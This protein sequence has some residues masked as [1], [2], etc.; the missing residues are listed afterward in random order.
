MSALAWHG[1]R[2]PVEKKKEGDTGLL[3]N[4]PRW[5]ATHFPTLVIEA[6]PSKRITARRQSAPSW[7]N[8]P[9]TTS[10]PTTPSPSSMA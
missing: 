4:P 2:I 6:G 3:P 10:P 8:G 1:I 5:A 7:H 9:A